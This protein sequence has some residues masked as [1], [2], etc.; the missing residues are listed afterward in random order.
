[1]AHIPICILI[2]VLSGFIKMAYGIPVP[3]DNIEKFDE[4]VNN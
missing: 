2:V 3:R 1:M 4:K